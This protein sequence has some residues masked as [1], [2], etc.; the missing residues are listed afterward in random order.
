MTLTALVSA[1]RDGLLTRDELFSRVTDLLS[2]GG[3][4]LS[5]AREELSFDFAVRS[6]FETWLK[7][8]VRYPKIL[9]GHKIVRV[10]PALV[11]EVVHSPTLVKA[12]R[13][14]PFVVSRRPV[15]LPTQRPA[16]IIEVGL[17]RII[18]SAVTPPIA[19]KTICIELHQEKTS[20]EAPTYEVKF[21]LLTEAER[22]AL[23]D[24]LAT[25]GPRP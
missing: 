25:L 4:S 24:G 1:Y 10:T 20:A 18:V 22:V 13:N 8:L 11:A 9:S 6:E 14:A 3:T 12:A 15:E 19:D 5:S 23:V 7:E 17:G 16:T 21:L 2:E